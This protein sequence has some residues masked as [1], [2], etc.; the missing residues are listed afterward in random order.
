MA[1][2][3]KYFPVVKQLKGLPPRPECGR[4]LRSIYFYL[5]EGCN[6]R[7]RHCWINPPFEKE[8]VLQFPYVGLDLFKNIIDQGT[9]LGVGIV[10]L[11]G[12]EPLMHPE[13]DKL[14]DHIIEKG[15]KLNIETNG[16]LLTPE[17]ARKI[18]TSK[19]SFVSVSLD[20]PESDMHEWVR[21]VPGCYDSALRGVWHLIDAGFKPQIIMS[22]MRRNAHQ[23]EELVRLAESLGAGSVKFN[24]VTPT[25]RG[26][27]MHKQNETLE[28][29]ELVKL[30]RFIDENLAKRT[31]IKLLYSSPPAFKAVSRL[32]QRRS[33]SGCG[34][35]NTLGVLGTGKYALC[36]IGESVPEL[37]FGDARTDSLA[38]V[39]NKNEVLNEIRQGLPLKLKGIC[40]DCVLKKGCLGS[41]IANNY[42]AYRDLFAPH[43]FCEKAYKEGLFPRSRLIPGSEYDLNW[44]DADEKEF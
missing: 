30:G 20:S 1:L 21:G 43:Q 37:V 19:G 4:Y 42:Y 23:V 25:A 9:G 27:K 7:C 22:V 24:L 39:W 16:V 44:A 18:R 33:I 15:L 26:E 11:T 40:R 13:I 32:K 8:A 36:G 38:D 10:K 14:I 29:E 12:G 31:S 35:F 41:C 34:I 3:Q 6:L 5:T 2:D 28:I 17:L